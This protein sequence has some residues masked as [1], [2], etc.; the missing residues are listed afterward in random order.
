MAIELSY[1]RRRGASF[2]VVVLCRDGRCS[3]LGY[4]LLSMAAIDKKAFLDMGSCCRWAVI[5]GCRNMPWRMSMGSLCRWG[6]WCF[7]T[8]QALT[9]IPGPLASI[10]SCLLTVFA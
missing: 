7:D 1:R 6:G 10:L 9:S 8:L 2:L 3:L 5:P 4:G